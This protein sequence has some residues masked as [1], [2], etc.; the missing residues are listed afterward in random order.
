MIAGRVR[1]AG[2]FVAVLLFVAL[3]HHARPLARAQPVR[4]GVPL[5][6]LSFTRLDGSPAWLAPRTG[7]PLV[8]NVFATWCPPC[9]DEMPA[10][11]R[12]APRLARAGID[13]VGIDQAESS[14]QV[15]RF[16]REYGLD[17]PLYIDDGDAN[18]YALGARVI[19][20]TLYVDAAGIVRIV[21]V[22]PLAA[23]EFLALAQRRQP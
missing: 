1:L 5:A 14:P 4:P 7:H 3:A 9:R 2:L 6:R 15:E 18:K 23:P 17:Y 12:A 20:T 8:V 10:L 16:A 13:V 21:H 19:P 22:G 11:A